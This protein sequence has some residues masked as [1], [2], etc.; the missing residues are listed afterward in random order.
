MGIYSNDSFEKNRDI[1]IQEE[2]ALFEMVKNSH[3]LIALNLGCGT[4]LLEGFVNIDKYSKLPGVQSDDIYMLPYGTMNDSMNVD[5][6][7]CAHVLEH[8]PIRHAKMAIKEWGR[9]M[10]TGGK[11][12]LGIPDLEIVMTMLLNPGLD[13]NTRTWLMYVLFGFQTDPANRG[14][15]L[16]YPVD[17]GQFHTSGYTK[18]IIV[19]ELTAVGFNCEKVLNYDG[20]GTPSIWV[21]AKKL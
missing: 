20:W 6:I 21:V 9:V 8:L 1:V 12:Y 5:V 18:D 14:D 3:N 17:P 7:F 15:N 19:K 2:Q 16:D 10:K 4:R 13:D 11:L